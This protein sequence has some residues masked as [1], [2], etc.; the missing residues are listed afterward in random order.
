MATL[1]GLGV[2]AI[3][4]NCGLGP[5]QMIPILEEMKQ[6]SSL[7]IIMKPNAGLPKQRNGETY[8][9]VNPEDFAFY[10][11]EIVKNGACV[12]GGC[13][14]TTPAHIKAMTDLCRGEKIVEPVYKTKTMVSSYGKAVEIGNMPII[15]GERINPT[16]KKR[17]KEA[18][19]TH[20]MDYILKEAVMQED[21]GAHILDVNV[22]LPDIDEVSMMKEAVQEIQSITN[23]PLQIDTVDAKA[24]EAALRIYNGKAMINSVSGK[25]E[26]MDLVFPLVKKYG[27]VVVALTL[28]ENG[29]PYKESNRHHKLIKLAEVNN[30]EFRKNHP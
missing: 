30:R 9:D 6:Y 22:G 12:I 10:M 25:K 11:K 2:D 5:V 21:K 29:I 27:G 28:D 14:G 19:K 18:L 7:P 15:I 1:E 4:V 13:C 16:G 3:G 20:D 17:F 24:L 23:L 26:S 8:Y